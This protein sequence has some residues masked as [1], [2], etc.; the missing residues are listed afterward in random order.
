MAQI[1][2]EA[3]MRLRARFIVDQL[4]ISVTPSSRLPRGGVCLGKEEFAR[5]VHASLQAKGPASMLR[6]FQNVLSWTAIPS[7][8]ASA[9]KNAA[10]EHTQSLCESASYMQHLTG[11]QA[12]FQ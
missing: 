8:V 9:R 11:S 1:G 2:G 4:L 7:P 6:D 12:D 10:E 5:I 3:T